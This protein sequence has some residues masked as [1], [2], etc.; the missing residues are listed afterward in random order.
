[1]FLH[2]FVLILIFN[3]PFRIIFEF[4]FMCIFIFMHPFHKCSC[5][6]LCL[7]FHHISVT[8]CVSDYRICLFLVFQ[9]ILK[10]ILFYMITLMYLYVFMFL[11]I[12]IFLLGTC[13]HLFYHMSY[14]H[15]YVQMWDLHFHDVYVYIPTSIAIRT[16]NYLHGYVYSHIFIS[17]R[18]SVYSL[19]YAD[20]QLYANFH[21][22]AYL[23]LCIYSSLSW[24][25]C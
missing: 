16:F 6:S 21:I 22:I 19:V 18:V 8:I 1:M 13:I 12:L 11:F 20:T 9:P 14:P 15:I 25:L 3:Y 4:M 10:F 23:H 5:L 24:W 2:F 17:I 7:S